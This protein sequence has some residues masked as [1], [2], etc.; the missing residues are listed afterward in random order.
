MKYFFANWKMYLDFDETMIL[1]NQLL[2]EIHATDV[3]KSLSVAFFPNTIAISEVIKACQDTEIAVGAQTVNWVPKGAY[4]G[5]VSAQLFSQLGC[6]YALLGHSERRYIFG[7]N[8]DDIRKKIEACID[9][10]ITPVICIGETISDVENGKE[11]YRIKKQLMKALDGLNISSCIVAYEPV[12]AIGTGKNCDANQ[13]GDRIAMIKQ[14]I[15]Q[16]TAHTVPVLYGGSVDE[17][18]VLSY[19][20][21]EIIDGVLVGKSSTTYDSCIGIIKQMMIR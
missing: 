20:Q 19:T 9:A 21:Q 1:T 12:W 15:L 10:N 11:E 3:Y 14:E 7:E 4:T 2:S 13:A 16:Y 8:N 5:A 6:S 17:H 18:N